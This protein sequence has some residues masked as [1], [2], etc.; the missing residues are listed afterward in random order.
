MT[1]LLFAFASDRRV[2][3]VVGRRRGHPAWGVD[4]DSMSGIY[5]GA[6][7]LSDA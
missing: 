5:G 6:I 3:K 4:D 1:G 2:D 7:V